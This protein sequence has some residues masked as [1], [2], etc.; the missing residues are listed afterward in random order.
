M[1]ESEKILQQI[2]NKDWNMSKDEGT[3]DAFRDTNMSNANW[4]P[5]A[6]V[7]KGI[8][9]IAEKATGSGKGAL[10]SAAMMLGA[11]LI[12]KNGRIMRNAA[13]NMR[14]YIDG[15]YASGISTLGKVGLLAKE[16]IKGTG[17]GFR[18][19]A[20][21]NIDLAKTKVG[22]EPAIKQSVDEIIG[23]KNLILKNK[24]N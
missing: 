12:L 16:G 10:I 3:I 5:E 9:N 22:L 23:A 4:Y 17:K 13:S 1:T 11:G 24:V 6:K 8:G 18:K 15:Y 21:V 19:L 14:N 20:D 7:F 2:V